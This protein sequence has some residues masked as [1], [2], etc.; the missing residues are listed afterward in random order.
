[1]DALQYSIDGNFHLNMKDRDTD[2]LDVA[3][4]DGAGYF[5]PS[6]TYKQFMSKTKAPKPEVCLDR[7]L[8]GVDIDVHLAQYLQP[9]RRHGPREVQRQSLRCGRDLLSTHVHP[10]EWYN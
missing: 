8:C 1:M 5:V 6:Q 7:A 9:V 3:L 4:S 10:G 2:P